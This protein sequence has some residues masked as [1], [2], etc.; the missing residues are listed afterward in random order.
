MDIVEIIKIELLKRCEEAKK[1]NG[2]DF[3]EEHIKYVVQNATQLAREYGADEEIAELGAL[4]HDIAMPS[5]IGPRE[6]H[7]IYGS[8]IAEELLQKHN[9]PKDRIERVKK[10]VLNHRGSRDLPRETIEEEIVADA[11]VIAH[12]DTIPSLFNLAFKELNLSIKEGTEYVKKKLERDYNKL[13][14][15]T[16]LLLQERYDNIR[17]VLFNEST[18][19]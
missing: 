3:W 7:H 15:R 18:D 6:D 1:R 13:S 8:Q 5:N 10:C 9:Y 4:L 19:K 11:D 2:F 16:K 12:F 14:D 17:K